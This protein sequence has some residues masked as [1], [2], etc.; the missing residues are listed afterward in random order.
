[1]QARE[2][3]D[4]ELLPCPFCGG[5]AGLFWQVPAR[6]TTKLREVTICSCCGATVWGGADA[7][8]SRVDI[9]MSL[10]HERV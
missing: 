9:E 4:V 1:M 8:N 10:R 3:N 6:G 2:A 7:W 5:E